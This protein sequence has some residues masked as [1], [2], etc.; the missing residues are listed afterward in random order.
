MEILQYHL[1]ETLSLPKNFVSLYND[2]NFAI[3]DIETTGL[4]PNFHNVVLIG[5][6]YIKNKK[7]VIEQFFCNNR[8][9]E[10]KLL[11]A[12]KE[13]IQEFD[14]LIDYNG[15][16]FDI[17]FLNKR[18]LLNN[19]D[20]FIE[21][22]KSMDLLKLIRKVQKNL[23]IENCKLKSIEKYLGIHRNDKISGKDSVLL[24]NQFEKEQ[25]KQL[26][27]IILLH[28]YDDL[29]YLG[30]ALMILDKIPYENIIPCFPNIFYIYKEN[31]CYVT[32]QFIKNGYFHLEGIYRN[33]DIAEYIAYESGFDFKYNKESNTFIIKIPLYKGQLSTG[34]K[35]L[36]ID[37]TD[38]S[39]SYNHKLLDISIPP[40]IILFK[41][42]QHIHTKKIYSFIA[43]LIPYILK[44]VLKKNHYS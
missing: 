11:T 19:I 41:E 9:E 34:S 24:Y 22:Y 31:I 16:A 44:K 38:F 25:D 1:E 7:I 21:N 35:C 26:K 36:Y 15:N 3:F 6:L 13:K 27:N 42:N 20:F 8:K 29:Y 18:F 33:E 12:F 14:L 39:F 28:N 32:K 4:S 37:I 23:C 43:V 40:N 2:I 10:V 30:K 5:I 17:P